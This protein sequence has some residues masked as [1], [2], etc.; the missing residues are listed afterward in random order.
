[1]F[2]IDLKRSERPEETGGSPASEEARQA[3]TAVLPIALV[4]LAMLAGLWVLNGVQ[5][6]ALER[7]KPETHAADL[8]IDAEQPHVPAESRHEML[9]RVRLSTD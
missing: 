7:Q 5:E 8:R 3:A 2:E 6:S 4:G 1:M 9:L